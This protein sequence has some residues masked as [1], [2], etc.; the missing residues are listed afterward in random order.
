M[1]VEKKFEKKN[2]RDILATETPK[3]ILRCAY[4]FLVRGCISGAAQTIMNILTQNHSGA[5]IYF[6]PV[7]YRGSNNHLIKNPWPCMTE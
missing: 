7:S 3:T 1:L 5:I 6:R 4:G 2:L